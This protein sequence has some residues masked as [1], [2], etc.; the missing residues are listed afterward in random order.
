M[1]V[2]VNI[3]NASTQTI[4]V[5]VNGGPQV[6]IGGTGAT[7]GWQPVSQPA[8]AGVSYSPGYPAPNVIGNLEV[9]NVTATVQGVPIGGAPFYFSLPTNYAV[10]SV[11]LYLFFGSVQSAN[12]IALTDGKVCGTQISSAL[13]PGTE[14]AYHHEKSA[15][16]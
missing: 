1:A 11:Q 12:W 16:E 10:G 13:A 9:N 15:G 7:A 5:V 2:P 8:S 3:F 4:T 6:S 14:L